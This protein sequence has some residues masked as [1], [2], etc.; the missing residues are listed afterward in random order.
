MNVKVNPFEIPL[1]PVYLS[2]STGIICMAFSV[3]F[4]T[5]DCINCNVY[6]KVLCID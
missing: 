2:L 3:N 4:H 6:D 1:W 5:F